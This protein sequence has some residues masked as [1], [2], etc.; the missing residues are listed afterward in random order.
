MGKSSL[1]KV[2]ANATPWRRFRQEPTT[3][4]PFGCSTWPLMYE[5]SSLARNT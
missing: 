5:A 1:A 3:L 2:E 4:P